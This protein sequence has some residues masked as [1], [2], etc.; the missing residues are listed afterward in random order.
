MQSRD[1]HEISISGERHLIDKF[2][3]LKLER[4]VRSGEEGRE[5]G[6]AV[7]EISERM[8]GHSSKPGPGESRRAEDH[9][10]LAFEPVHDEMARV[11]RPIAVPSGR[12]VA[13]SDKQGL[14][15]RAPR[16]RKLVL[17]RKIGD[18]AEIKHDDLMKRVIAVDAQNYV[19]GDVNE[20]I[21]GKQ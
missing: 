4:E 5:K 20:P 11:L 21:A 9:I 17:V 13:S 16:D 6:D 3:P 2:Q 12:L 7:P 10:T 1:R 8:H 15:I 14:L 19:V 18:A